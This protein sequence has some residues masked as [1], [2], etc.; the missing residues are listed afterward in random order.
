M[1]D[2]QA[3]L[4][5]ELPPLLDAV[6]LARH[7][8]AEAQRIYRAQPA[9]AHKLAARHEVHRALAHG[10]I[11]RPSACAACGDQCSP[12][13]HHHDHSEP[14]AIEWLCRPCHMRRH[15]LRDVLPG[16]MSLPLGDR[17]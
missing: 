13:A 2:G 10:E 4:F 1:T 6:E 8:N 11:S 9:N 17:R 5:P 3:E 12:E 15:R 16:Q 14:L 7:R